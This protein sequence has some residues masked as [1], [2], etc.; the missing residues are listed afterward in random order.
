MRQAL[1]DLRYRL[2]ALFRRNTMDRE[3]DAELRFH[4]EKEVEKHVRA[5][6]T[7]DEARRR[8][9]ATFGAM[10]GIKDDTRDARGLVA[11]ETMA[12]DIRYAAR[13]LMSRPV[14]TGGVILTL[15]L[16]IGAN[17][18]MFGIVDRL[19]F[20]AAPSLRDPG[21]L[22]RVYASYTWDGERRKRSD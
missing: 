3:L 21:T 2:R 20:R 13:G 19:L 5:G 4:V 12:Q 18:A 11:L 10:E 22:H 9:R 17:A 6:M 8:A 1:N 16:G 14:F 7:P 15:G